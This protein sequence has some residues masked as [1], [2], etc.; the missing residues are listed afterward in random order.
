MNDTRPTDMFLDQPPVPLPRSLQQAYLWV[1]GT[2]SMA[3]TV[4]VLVFAVA[5]QSN[6]D[7]ERIATTQEGGVKGLLSAIVA[8][9]GRPGAI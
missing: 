4:L 7:S 3:G 8:T 5:T 6:A 9:H 1:L 2:V